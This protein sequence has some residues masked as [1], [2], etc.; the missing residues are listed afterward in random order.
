MK[1]LMATLIENDPI[2]RDENRYDQTRPESRAKT[3]AKVKRVQE[4]M[5]LHQ[6]TEIPK[7]SKQDKKRTDKQRATA[8]AFWYMMSS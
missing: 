1:T 8:E 7:V 5:N 2:L 6:Q 4:M 3:M